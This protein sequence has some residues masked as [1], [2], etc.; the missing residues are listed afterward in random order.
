MEGKELAAFVETWHGYIERPERMIAVP[1]DRGDGLQSLDRRWRRR[2][3]V[4]IITVITACDFAALTLFPY[5]HHSAIDFVR[6]FF[7]ELHNFLVSKLGKQI[8]P[9]WL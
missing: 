3:W 6:S 4:G 8:V 5:I 9:F 7:N 2:H 1:D